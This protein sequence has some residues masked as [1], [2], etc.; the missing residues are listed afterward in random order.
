MN[1]KWSYIELIL[2]VFFW[3]HFLRKR[4]II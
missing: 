1:N 2:S 3:S 4:K